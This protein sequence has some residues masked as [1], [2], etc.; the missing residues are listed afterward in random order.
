MEMGKYQ[1]KM[2]ICAFS[3][4]KSKHRVQSAEHRVHSTEYGLQSKDC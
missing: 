2:T 3:Q 4:I 1:Y